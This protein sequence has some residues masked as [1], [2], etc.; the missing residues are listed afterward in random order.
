[1]TKPSQILILIMVSF[2]LINC[3]QKTELTELEFE[4]KVFYELFPELSDKMYNDIRLIPTPPPPSPNYLTEKGFDAENDYN[5]ALDDWEKSDDY[6]NRL[7]DWK[8]RRDSIITDTTLIY[9]SFPDSINQFER[10][11][12][13]ELI[14]H[15][16]D[17]KLVVDSKDFELNSGFKV[18]FDNLKSDNKKL[19][20]KP[21]S[22]FPERREFW[23]TKY[24]F[25]FRGSM[26]ITRILFDKTK[27][28]GV[29]NT[30]FV[31]GRLNGSGCR[32][33]IRKDE[34]GNWVIDKI[35]GTWIS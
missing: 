26:S 5:K 32:V 15:F 3:E 30:G 33:F 25:N 17:Q 21:L 11:D 23:T 10:E 27:S 22:E 14:N 20:F 6:R 29:L 31:K 9:I 35:K 7:N 8:K 1:M 18:D 2:T 34:N 12:M 13:H 19:R 16:N 24:D 4:Q 28:F